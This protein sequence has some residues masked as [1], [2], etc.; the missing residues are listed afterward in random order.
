MLI[1]LKCGSIWGIDFPLPKSGENVFLC[2]L[3]LIELFLMKFGGTKLDLL[4]PSSIL[5]LVCELIFLL[6]NAQDDPEDIMCNF[7]RFSILLLD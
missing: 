2:P 6:L 1:T 4:P 5:S 3:C 7:M